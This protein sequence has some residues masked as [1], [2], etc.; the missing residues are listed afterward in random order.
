MKGITD[1]FEKEQIDQILEAA[2][3]YNFRDY[4]TVCLFVSHHRTTGSF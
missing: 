1:Y 3:T 2:E 4:L